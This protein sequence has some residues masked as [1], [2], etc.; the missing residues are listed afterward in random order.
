M[1]F[2]RK[3]TDPLDEYQIP[4]DSQYRWRADGKRDEMFRIN[5]IGTVTPTEMRQIF[6]LLLNVLDN[7]AELGFIALTKVE[8]IEP[9]TFDYRY[10]GEGVHS[11]RTTEMLDL[12]WRIH[13]VHPI[14]N[15]DGIPYPWFAPK[16]RQVTD[17]APPNE[18][19]L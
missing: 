17:G 6:T 10:V 11:G 8:F 19:A 12:W 5:F 9:D 4:P 3:L 13:T 16:S 2:L 7:G 18:P 15:V 14:R 1:S